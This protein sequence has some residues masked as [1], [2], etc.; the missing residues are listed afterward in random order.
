GEQHDRGRCLESNREHR[1][2]LYDGGVPAT[3]P[4]Q[5]T[6][7]GLLTAIAGS[8]LFAWLIWTVGPAE[9]WSGFRQIGWNLG[10]I[11]LLGG[12]RFAVRAGAWALCIEPPHRLPL[13]DAF[14]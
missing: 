6:R 3:A 14:T 4:R 11:L 12:L 1:R 8:A 7:V 5:I 2:R 13:T 10:W 9:I